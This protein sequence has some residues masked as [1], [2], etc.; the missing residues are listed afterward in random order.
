MELVKGSG[1]FL[2]K[3]TICQAHLLP[4]FGKCFPYLLKRLFSQRE[5]V[6]LNHTGVNGMD[7]FPKD[8]LNVI[9]IFCKANTYDVVSRYDKTRTE[10]DKSRINEMCTNVVQSARHYLKFGKKWLIQSEEEEEEEKNEP[11]NATL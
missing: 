4:E 6:T 10:I 11:H 7:E 3:D 8:L 9:Q 2:K 1:I 5:L